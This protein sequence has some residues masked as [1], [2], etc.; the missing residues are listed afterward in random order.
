[1]TTLDQLRRY[2][3]ARS[4][5]SVRNVNAAVARL[6]YVQADPIRAPARAQDLILYQRVE[7]Y[8]VDDLEKKYPKLDVFEDTLHNYGF[9]PRTLRNLMYPRP[10]SPHKR[11]FFDE[12]ASLRRD[13]MRYLREQETAHPRDLEAALAHGRRT[14]GWGGSSSATTLMLEAL[15]RAGQV[16]VVKRDAGIRIY[17]KVDDTK[18]LRLSPTARADGL[19]LLVVNLYAPIP[20]R[21]LNS[22]VA[23]IAR[24]WPEVDFK[25]RL[26]LM[27]RSGALAEEV[28]EGESYIW[29]MNEKIDVNVPDRVRLLAPFDPVVWDRRRFEHFWGWAYR[30]EAYTPEAKRVRGY[31]ALP[32]LWQENIIGWANVRRAEKGSGIGL[33]VALGYVNKLPRG[34]VFKSALEE[35]IERFKAFLDC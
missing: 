12:H 9:F 33:D 2:A 21:S 13:V 28:V 32:L 16:H 4:L 14:N 34:S 35:E 27:L 5:F 24:Y 1:V 31:Y 18:L 15:H 20:R 10:L 22:L 23:I 7:K 11:Q 17:A 19:I 26:Q 6:G 8:R 30:F 29:P 3:V 25:M